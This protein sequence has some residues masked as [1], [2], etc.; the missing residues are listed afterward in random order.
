MVSQQ[1]GFTLIELMIVT[2]IVSIVAGVA[3]PNLVSSRAVANERAVV[4]TLRTISTAQ[5]QCQ[6]RAVVDVDRD[7]SGEALGL[8]ELAGTTPLRGSSAPLSPAVLATSLGTLDAAGYAN[9]KGY[10]IALYLPDAAG[11]GVLATPANAASIDADLAE[12]SWACVAW[13]RSRGRSGT[14]SFYVNQTGEIL[15]AKNASYSGTTSVPPAGAAMSGVA[16][17]TISGAQLAIDAVGAD[18]NLWRILR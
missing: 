16:A 10:F 17:T 7:G 9:S 1:S 14:A 8:A 15:V 11:D 2:A 3:V 4:A 6:T 5:T 12:I 13:P 18:G